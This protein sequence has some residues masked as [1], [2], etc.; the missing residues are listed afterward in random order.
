MNAVSLPPRAVDRRTGP[1]AVLLLR[2]S[3]GV[4][5]LAH[6][7]V[8][9]LLTFGLPGTAA[10]FAGVGLPGALAYVTFAAEVA[11]GVLLILGVQTRWVALAVSPI[12]IGALVFVHGGNGW[13]FASPNGG[14]EYPLY[15]F[16]LCVAQALL[17]DG[18]YALSPSWVPRRWQASMDV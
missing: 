5:F 11:A 13:M 7:I 14:W 18:P 10:F 3:L 9:K 1:A 16:V 12:L 4:M 15:L 8:L 6:S 2:L 17:G